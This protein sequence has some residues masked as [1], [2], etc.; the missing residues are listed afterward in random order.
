MSSTATPTDPQVEKD[1]Y[2]KDVSWYSKE[3]EGLNPACR[4]LL[5]RY[6]HIPPDEVE[7]HV[8]EIVRLTSTS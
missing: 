1:Q 2:S 4:E 5:E 8:F 6:S 7:Q 3:I